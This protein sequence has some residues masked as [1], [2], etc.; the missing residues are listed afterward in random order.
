MIAV[1][2]D[3]TFL[4]SQMNYQRSIFRKIYQY[5]KRNG[6]HFVATSGN[7][8]YQLKSF[9]DDYQDEITYV[10]ENGALIIGNKQDNFCNEIPYSDVETIV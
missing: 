10:S 1:D 2:M 4:D 8:Y 9:F 3:G 7:Q 5:F 6:I